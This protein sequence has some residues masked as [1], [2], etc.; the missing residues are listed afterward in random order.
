MT[1][2]FRKIVR[3]TWSVQIKSQNPIYKTHGDILCLQN[4]FSENRECRSMIINT[5]AQALGCRKRKPHAEST[6]KVISPLPKQFAVACCN[7]VIPFFSASSNRLLVLIL[8]FYPSSPL[9]LCRDPSLYFATPCIPDNPLKLKPLLTCQSVPCKSVCGCEFVWGCG[10]SVRACNLPA[11]CSR[12]CFLW[13]CG[14][15]AGRSL[16]LLLLLLLYLYLRSRPPARAATLLTMSRSSTDS[17]WSDLRK[18]TGTITLFSFFRWVPSERRKEGRGEE[19][20]KP[21]A[22]LQKNKETLDRHLHFSMK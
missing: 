3:W 2:K 17:I 20:N 4:N 1:M 7:S 8:V 11:E 22:F 21:S 5:V 6:N 18:R 13:C 16:L 9:P 12:V 15:S 14:W 10:E 19:V